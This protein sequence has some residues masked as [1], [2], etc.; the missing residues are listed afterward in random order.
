MGVAAAG[1]ST[2]RPGYG[3]QHF[4]TH[5]GWMGTMGVAVVYEPP[6]SIAGHGL[7]VNQGCVVI[8]APVSLFMQAS[9]KIDTG[10]SGW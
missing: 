9:E 6:V 4:G 7:D 2:H 8:F 1:S 5:M 10:M 3:P